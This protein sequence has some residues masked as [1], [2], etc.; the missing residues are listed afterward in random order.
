MD[1]DL[2]ASLIASGVAAVLS[3]MV[4]VIK[5]VDA[6]SLFLRAILGGLIFGALIY[7]GILLIRRF[8]PELLGEGPQEADVGQEPG[9]GVNIVLPGEGPDDDE[10]NAASAGGIVD[11]GSVREKGVGAAGPSFRPRG[12]RPGIAAIDEDED[13]YSYENES[14]L[15]DE[16][17]GEA[18][19][20]LGAAALL[21]AS[22]PEGGTG[23]GS[24]NGY[25]AGNGQIAAARGEVRQ[26]NHRET[27][28]VDDID[29][30]P[31]LDTL[32]GGFSS[33]AP[34]TSAPIQHLHEDTAPQAREAG[35]G[36]KADPTMLAQAVRTLLK[37][38]QE[39]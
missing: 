4:G 35:G 10:A 7:G 15:D 27:M 26:P 8:L 16:G 1:R 28:G 9:S 22:E 31:D 30:L 17:G 39:R 36:G 25:K 13:E 32:S 5:R 3:I 29:V 38:D 23:N 37:R 2:R 18:V 14:L 12:G 33:V 19:A 21:A 6:L 20:G 34:E 11:Q 24:R